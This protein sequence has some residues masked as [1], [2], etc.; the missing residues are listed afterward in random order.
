M[1]LPSQRPQDLSRVAPA[2]LRS[3]EAARTELPA[4]SWA[5]AAER[6]VSSRRL[7]RFLLDG[8]PWE[9]TPEGLSNPARLELGS[10]PSCG[11]RVAFD[12]WAG[13][14]FVFEPG[15]TSGRRGHECPP[16]PAQ[17]GRGGER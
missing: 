17:D 14:E 1:S 13:E 2:A 7:V 12:A 5:A 16:G 9:V 15:T 4:L 11:A 3:P 8:V 10:C 6:A